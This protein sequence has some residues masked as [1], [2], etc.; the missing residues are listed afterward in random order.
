MFAGCNNI[1]NINFIN[2]DTSNSNTMEYMFAD[3]T[4]LEKL[5]LSSFNT[6]N[7]VNMRNMFFNCGNLTNLDLSSFDTKNVINMSHIFDGCKKLENIDLLFFVTNK[8]LNMSNMFNNC[9]LLKNLNLSSFNTK[10]VIDMSYMFYNCCNLIK[11]D[12]S[13]FDTKNVTN[14]SHIFDGCEKLDDVNLLFFNTY[15]VSNM[16]YMFSNCLQLKNLNLSSFKTEN[17]IDMSYMFYNCCNLTNLDLSLFDTENVKDMSNMF[18][19]C[20][21]LANLEL[22]SFDT[23]NIT[24]MSEMFFNCSNLTNLELSSFDFRNVE[25]IKDI[26]TNC[27]RFN[28]LNLS[29]INNG[30]INYAFEFVI[31][32]ISGIQINEKKDYL[33]HKLKSMKLFKVKGDII[34]YKDKIIFC[35]ENQYYI[36]NLIIGNDKNINDKADY[37]ILEYDQN[38]IKSLE[39]IEM[40]W[41]KYCTN[42]IT[43]LC[44]LIGIN[45]ETNKKKIINKA[46]SF[47][48]SNKIEHILISA[49][50]EKDINNAIKDIMKNLTIQE[51]FYYENIKII[52]LDGGTNGVGKTSIIKRI[53]NEESNFPTF[54]EDCSKTI[55][56]KT[57]NEVTLNFIDTNDY[58]LSEIEESHFIL[59]IYDV[60]RKY[61]F[62][63]IKKIYNGNKDL[64]G[65]NKII[66]L[67]GNKIDLYD[68]NRKDILFEKNEI[69]KFV[70]QNNLRF[71]EI[72]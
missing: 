33:I 69:M 61:S 5:N 47:C 29:L 51:K 19:G 9:L 43:N 12:L 36:L 14:M 45:F 4:K 11:L 1:K 71:F 46:N 6:K 57:G 26:F 38:D 2:F 63:G 70:E 3:C 54:Q 31:L 64:F 58:I 32:F 59:F 20:E 44:H 13:S 62:D 15:K 28:N 34:N 65:E 50:N 35:T 67:I 40:I 22:S 66:Y 56:L 39:T 21:K 23:K 27:G 30:I 52:F 41:N 48:S 16:R 42:K 53:I 17:V 68:K 49:I 18:C 37:L 25:K 10:N 7:V 60:T 8:V 55:I 72:S 24:N